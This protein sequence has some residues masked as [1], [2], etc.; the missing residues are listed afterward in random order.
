LYCRHRRL[1]DRRRHR[2]R[3]PALANL[4]TASMSSL[5]GPPIVVVVVTPAIPLPSLGRP[6]RATITPLG[7][8][9][10]RSAVVVV[11][12]LVVAHRAVAII[13]DF[14]ARRAV[15]IVVVISRRRRRPSPSSPSFLSCSTFAR[16]AVECLC[17]A[18][19][20]DARDN[21]QLTTRRQQRRW[22]FDN[23][24]RQLWTIG[25]AAPVEGDGGAG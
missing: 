23:S 15:A 17:R 25:S 7:I 3:L 24:W 10:L 19:A 12:V 6:H 21:A 16:R 9:V 5:P 22:Y 18:A 8:V 20:A 2:H 1:S 4:P 13:V 11:V 14:D